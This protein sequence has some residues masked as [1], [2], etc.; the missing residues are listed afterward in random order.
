[1]GASSSYSVELAQWARALRF[2]DLP[3]DVVRSTKYRVLDVIGLA[4]AGVTTPFGASL[5]QR[6][7]R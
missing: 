5:K 4:L 3:A 2:E 6:P 7:Q 1:M